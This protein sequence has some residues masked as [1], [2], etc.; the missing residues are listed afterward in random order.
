MDKNRFLIELSES[1]RSQYGKVDYASQSPPQRVFSAIWG[2]E[3]QVNNGGFWQYFES[4]DGE[5]AA[6]VEA[7][8]RT[9]GAT[10]MAAIVGDAVRLFPGGSPPGDLEARRQRL[11]RASTAQRETWYVLDQRFY[12]YPDDLTELLY[13]F[14]QAHPGEF[15]SPE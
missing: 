12:E 9:I 2:L 11:A 7:F 4:A 14:V 8:L 13:A 5:A 1:P 6:D 10:R 3:S 15:G